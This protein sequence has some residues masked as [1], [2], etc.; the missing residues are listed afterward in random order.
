MR[1]FKDNENFTLY[2]IVYFYDYMIKENLEDIEVYEAVKGKFPGIYWCKKYR[3]C[4]DK[5]AGDDECGGQCQGHT[6]RNGVKGVCK[7]YFT[8]LYFPGKK[9]TLKNISYER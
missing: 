9:V 8:S 1:Y 4:G 2:D 7:H 5:G 6:P 3:Y